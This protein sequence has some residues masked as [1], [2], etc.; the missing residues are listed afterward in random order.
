MASGPALA[1]GGRMPGVGRAV[2]VR[3]LCKCLK[4]R[5]ARPRP[6]PAS[7]VCRSGAFAIS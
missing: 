3:A 1:A 4:R 5:H 7:T 6:W 2:R